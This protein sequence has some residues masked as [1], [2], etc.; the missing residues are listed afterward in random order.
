VPGDGLW[1]LIREINKIFLLAGLKREDIASQGLFLAL[2]FFFSS[3]GYLLCS[4]NQKVLWGLDA[5]TNLLPP[6]LHDRY[7][8]VVPNADCLIN[9][10]G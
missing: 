2:G 3:S 8:D 10:S 6:H 4:Q 9:L 5:Q 1:H 7:S